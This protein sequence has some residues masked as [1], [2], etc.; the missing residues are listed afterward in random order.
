[1]K[2]CKTGVYSETSVA[3]PRL[4]FRHLNKKLF[5]DYRYLIN[6]DRFR[7]EQM[8]AA[9]GH[10]PEAV[11]YRTLL[12]ANALFIT[13]NYGTARTIRF[14]DPHCLNA[15]ALFT[16][17]RTQFWLFSLMR[18][19]IWIQLLITVD[20]HLRPLVYKSFGAPFWASTPLVWASTVIQGSILSL[21]RSW[22]QSLTRIR[23]QIHLFVWCGFSGLLYHSGLRIRSIIYRCEPR[24][25]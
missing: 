14:A 12:H 19:W 10:W 18:T 16:L 23:I 7:T 8:V 11:R 17:M 22:I 25:Y 13:D 3:Q 9:L 4:T 24:D 2:I 6:W 20:A 15:D 21:Y 1:M 5:T